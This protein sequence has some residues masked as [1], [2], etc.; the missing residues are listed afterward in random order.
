L[1]TDSD[2]KRPLYELIQ[3]QC[4]VDADQ[5]LEELKAVNADGSLARL[6]R[7]RPGTALLRRARAVSDTGRRP[8]EY[9][10]V[11]YRCERFTLTLKLRQE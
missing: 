3:E 4:S 6:L 1:T 7:V 8:I 11:H 9:A 5:S 2:F 10:E